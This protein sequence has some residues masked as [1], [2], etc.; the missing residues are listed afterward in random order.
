[1]QAHGY[2][3]PAADQPLAPFTFER[4]EPGPHDVAIDITHCGVCHSDLH[5]ARAEWGGVM[6]PCVPGHE[7]VG[8]V[9]AVGAHV[10]KFKAGDFVGV[11]CMVDSCQHC[12]P[13]AE[14]V[15]QYCD[16]GFTGTYNGPEQGTGA[17]TYGG[18][19]DKIVVS[20]KFVLRVP[21]SLDPAAAARCSALASPPTRRCATGRSG[22]ARR[23]RS[24]AWAVSA[25]W[26]S[27]SPTP[28]GPR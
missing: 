26:A 28:W 14:G 6:F 13:C 16:N 18:Y 24:W 21:E 15:E 20:E 7:I 1:M 19:S 25:T 5:T 12:D 22:P 17:N 23:S 11:G 10:T 4:R 2:A 3:A 8:R 9:S 27:S